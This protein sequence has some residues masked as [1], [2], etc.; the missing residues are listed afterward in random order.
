MHAWTP[1]ASSLACALASTPFIP[2]FIHS[3]LSFPFL[4]LLADGRTDGKVLACGLRDLRQL[5]DAV[6]LLAA[7]ESKKEA[8]GDGDNDGGGGGGGEEGEELVFRDVT[9][10][11]QWVY[12]EA[13]A[14][15]K[16]TVLAGRLPKLLY[17][18]KELGEFVAPM[19]TRRCCGGGGG[20]LGMA[21][22]RL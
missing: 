21:F 11:P 19:K 20:I 17:Q 16:H 6:P 22:E 13:A 8:G 9:P 18:D 10:D 15:E 5:P 14:G 7:D 1:F 3:F 4:A 2:S 12:V